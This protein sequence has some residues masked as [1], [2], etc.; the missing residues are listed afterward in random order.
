MFRI[1]I[2][3]IT[4]PAQGQAI[5]RMGATDL[6]FICV[7]SSPRYITP[8]Q[9]ARVVA[10]VP[11]E[12][13]KVGVFANA[14]IPQIVDVVSQGNLSAV[15][16]H[17]TESLEFCRELRSHLANVELI[18][19]GRIRDRQDLK[20]ISSYAT[21]V[22]TLLLDAYHPQ[23]LGG[24]GHTIDWE[25][26]QDFNPPIPWLLAGGLHPGNI[27]DALAQLKPHGIDL[28]S[29]VELKP[30]NKDLSLVERLFTNLADLL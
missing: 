1:K 16:L 24:T 23:I 18:K 20:T 9:I 29:G 11:A 22:D 13:N 3:G 17:G 2:C 12:V 19:A 6:G 25:Q 28:S 5:A 21:I 14:S 8:E 4:I 10:V 7:A 26:L 15:Q 30:G 27:Q